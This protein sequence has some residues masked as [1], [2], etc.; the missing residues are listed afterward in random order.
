MHDENK[1]I[2]PEIR[3]AVEAN[4][5]FD[6]LSRGDLDLAARAQARLRELGWYITRE[7]PRPRRRT[8]R[9]PARRPGGVA[10]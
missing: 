9:Q 6:A 5:L 3:A 7:A 10:S 2:T 8:A 4:C 1:L